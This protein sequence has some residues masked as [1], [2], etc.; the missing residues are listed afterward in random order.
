MPNKIIIDNSTGTITCK[1]DEQL[2]IGAETSAGIV[3]IYGGSST[4]YIAMQSGGSSFGLGLSGVTLNTYGVLGIGSQGDGFHTINIFANSANNSSLGIR[5][6]NDG[7]G[8]GNLTLAAKT[9]I[10]FE[11]Q[12]SSPAANLFLGLG[13]LRFENIYVYANNA[14][15][16]DSSGVIT[17]S[18]AYRPLSFSSTLRYLS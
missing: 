17:F 15:S 12:F 4:G 9:A 3:Q 7:T 6:N 18:D 2:T 16:L 1:T 14:I 8:E 13:G 11:P 5:S 10:Y